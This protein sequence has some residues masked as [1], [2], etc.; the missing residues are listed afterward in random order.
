MN[1]DLSKR[2]AQAVVGYLNAS[3]IADDRIHAAGYGETRPIAPNDTEEGKALNRRI[4]FTI[5]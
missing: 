1:L 4:E 3:G 5:Q 2:R